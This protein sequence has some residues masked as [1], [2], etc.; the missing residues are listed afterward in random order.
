MRV[1]E[2]QMLEQK[3]I[4]A[5]TAA[6]MLAC[7]HRQLVMDT[8][9]DTALQ[10]KLLAKALYLIDATDEDLDKFERSIVGDTLLKLAD[11]KER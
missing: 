9:E 6:L 10:G 3:L 1:M 4:C 11:D 5:R 7:A 2:T 8:P